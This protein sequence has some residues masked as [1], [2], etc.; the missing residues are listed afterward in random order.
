MSERLFGL[1]GKTL[2]HSF[3]KNYFTEKFRQEGIANCRYE[4]FPLPQIEA[5]S[6]LLAA[7]PALEGINVT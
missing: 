4:L 7:H 3:S 2:T 6:A 5:F 1:I